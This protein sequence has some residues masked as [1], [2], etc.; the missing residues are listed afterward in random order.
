MPYRRRPDLLGF[1]NGLQLLF[2]ELKAHHKSVK[3][4]YEDNLSDY[5]DTIPHVFHHNA[6]C[7]LS[8]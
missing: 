3:T 6:V 5:L 4:A 8:A 1:V 2:I 7:M